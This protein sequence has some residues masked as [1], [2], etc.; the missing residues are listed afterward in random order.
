MSRSLNEQWVS[1]SNMTQRRGRA[2]RTMDG[3]CYHLYTEKQFKSFD[4]FP[5]PDIQKTDLSNEVLDLMKGSKD[6]RTIGDLNTKLD[7]LMEPPYKVFRDSALN[8][9]E[10]LGAITSS[11]EHG[12]LTPL[13]LSISDFRAIEP[14]HA[15]ALISSYNYFCKDDVIDIISMLQL[16]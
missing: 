4:P 2:G 5:I 12:V 14:I 9:L 11:K 10:S 8:I 13:G 15:R 6:V 7:E 3:I 1:Q 16:S